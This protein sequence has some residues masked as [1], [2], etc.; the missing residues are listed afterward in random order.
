MKRDRERRELTPLAYNNAGKLAPAGQRKPA[1]PGA[2]MIITGDGKISPVRPSLH[3][4]QPR[5]R[6]MRVTFLSFA[7]CVLLALLFAS[8]PITAG[9]SGQVGN[10][11]AGAQAWK[12]PTAT[13]TPTPTLDPSTVGGPGTGYNPGAA[14]I[15]NEIKATFGSYSAGALAVAKCESGYDPNAWNPVSIMGSHAEGVFQILFPATW[16]NTS[17]AGYSPYNAW[18]N[19]HAAYQIFSRDGYSWREW[20]CQP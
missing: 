15:I 18:A 7:S 19:I 1:G 14:T 4:P 11:I 9:A 13:P 3:R 6:A 5:S 17:Y 12:L 20:Q 10:F 8:T 16:D 2:P